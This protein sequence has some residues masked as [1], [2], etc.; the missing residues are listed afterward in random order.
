MNIEMELSAFKT[1]CPNNIVIFDKNVF[2]RGA[3]V[4]TVSE[5]H[6]VSNILCFDCI[7]E[8]L[9]FTMQECDLKVSSLIIVDFSGDKNSPL[10]FFSAM[11]A[12]FS[13][14]RHRNLKVLIYTSIEDR[15]FISAMAKSIFGGIVLKSESIL[16]MKRVLCSLN[17]DSRVVLSERVSGL[18]LDYRVPNVSYNELQGYFSEIGEHRL[19][20]SSRR[21]GSKYKTFYSRRYNT[22]AKIGFKSVKQY[23]LYISKIIGELSE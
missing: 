6:P 17:H 12:Y 5:I 22:I 20:Q 8:A 16:S 18:L 9:D 13:H 15:F 21:I 3:I 4:D 23:Y 19:I 2:S 1:W 10:F 7:I 11:S 14:N